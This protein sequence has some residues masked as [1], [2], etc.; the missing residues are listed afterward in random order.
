MSEEEVVLVDS[1]DKVLGTMPKMEAHKKAVLHRAFSV[2]L[3]NSKKELLLQKRADNKYHSP[4][5]WT[6]TCC[7]HQRINETTIQAAKRRLYQEMGINASLKEIFKFKYKV[8]FNN[9]LTEHELDH[10]LVGFSDKNPKINLNEVSDWKWMSLE[11]ISNS[12]K[13]NPE[14]YTVWFK[15]VFNQFYN[16]IIN[17]ESYN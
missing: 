12:I 3:M 10:V 7:S 4:G 16:F 14:I 2:F 11:L 15:I 9:G 6:N 17:N 1:N 5:L 13:E 8:S